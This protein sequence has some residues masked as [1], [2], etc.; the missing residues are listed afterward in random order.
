MTPPAP[1]APA[2]EGRTCDNCAHFRLSDSAED[3]AGSGGRCDEWQAPPAPAAEPSRSVA[4]RV[5]AQ[6]GRS[7]PDF[8]AEPEVGLTEAQVAKW[9]TE[10]GRALDEPGKGG[11]FPALVI[12]LC[13]DDLRLRAERVAWETTGDAALGDLAEI[14]AERDAALGQLREAEYQRVEAIKQRDRSDAQLGAL[15]EARSV[16]A[17]QWVN[18]AAEFR[19]KAGTCDDSDAEATRTALGQMV[20]ARTLDGCADDLLAAGRAREEGDGDDDDKN[21]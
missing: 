4:R 16:L 17:G 8:S 12:A 5:A 2:G 20:V 18:R 10:A 15:R 13:N 21:A 3:C 11:R 7:A 9:R 14:L 6:Q 19:L 1:A